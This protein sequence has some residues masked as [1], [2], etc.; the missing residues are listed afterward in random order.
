MPELLLKFFRYLMVGFFNTLLCV[1][2]MY[3]GWLMGLNYLQFTALGYASSITLSF[4]MN[5]RYTFRVSGSVGKRLALFWVVCL[6][7]LCFVEL[8]EYSLVE[9][10]FIDRFIAIF[11]GMCWYVVTGFL[12]NNFLVYRQ[13]IENN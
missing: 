5:L 13:R 4:F 8:I 1:T 11:C 10:F 2:V 9:W 7:N 12:V 3:L 6:V